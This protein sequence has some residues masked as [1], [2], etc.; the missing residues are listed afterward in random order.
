[1]WATTVLFL[2]SSLRMVNHWEIDRGIDRNVY[3]MV[4]WQTH[5]NRPSRDSGISPMEIEVG[6][7]A[8]ET[9]VTVRHVVSH[10]RDEDRMS[11]HCRKLPHDGPDP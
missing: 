6:L 7:R 8:E 9:D 3:H 2:K 4:V 10:H 1:M 5:D 11:L